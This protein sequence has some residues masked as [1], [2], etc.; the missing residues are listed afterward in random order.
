VARGLSAAAPVPGRF[1]AIDGGQ[2]FTV[3]VD[4]AHK[5]DALDQA[6]RAAR[7]L[8]A[9]HAPRSHGRSGRRRL[10]V[11]FGCGGDRDIAK[12]P[13]MGEVATR[14]ADDVILTSDNP[15]SEDPLAIIDDIRAGI[16][17]GAAATVAVEPD[18]RRAI[19]RAVAHARPGD[20]VVIAGKGHETTQ[21]I[22]DT[23]RPFDDREV[24]RATL[25]AVVPRARGGE[26]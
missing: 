13:L 14:L 1:E 3:L 2:L 8:V 12:R 25:A 10:L 24:A 4:Y 5:P 20:V 9:E 26:R 11:V 19:E 16:T 15:R 7:E 22:G 6:L 18:R 23:V 17:P 21:T